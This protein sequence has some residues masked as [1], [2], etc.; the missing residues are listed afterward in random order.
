MS[1]HV[2]MAERPEP[3]RSI[4]SAH[5]TDAGFEVV[6]FD[7]RNH[8]VH[9]LNPVSSAIWVLLDGRATVDDVTNELAGIF[10]LEIDRIANDVLRAI[11][12][13][14]ALG[15]LEGSPPPFGA[16]AERGPGQ[17]EIL[18]RPPDP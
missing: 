13:F 7:D 17:A 8:R 3:A 5:F 18:S 14:W 16:S 2:V 6:L 4:E 1:Q 10:D 15:L 9:R 12:E 11:E